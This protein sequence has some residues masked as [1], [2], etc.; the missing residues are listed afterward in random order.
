MKK[1]NLAVIGTGHLGKFH[2]EKLANLSEVNLKALVDI[3]LD[4]AQ[5]VA[6]NLKKRYQIEPEV[7]SDFRKVIE[8]VEAVVIATPTITHYEIAKEF[9]LRKKAVFLEKPIASSWEHSLE[10]VEISEKEGVPFQI[11]YVERF[12][13]PVKL[14]MEKVLNPLFIEAHRLS[15]FVERNLDIDVV[16][17]LMIH[18]LDLALYLKGYPKIKMIHAVGAPLFSDHYD[19]VNAR[20]VFEDETTANFTASRV[21]LKK[22]RRFRVFEK[23]VYYVV[24]TLEKS[25][26]E[27][28]VNPQKREFIPFKRGFLNTDPLKEE[29]KAFVRSVLYGER[30]QVSGREA[31]EALRLAFL[32]KNSVESHLQKLK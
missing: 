16:L 7:Y 2:A 32:I 29:L 25:F 15:S 23:G 6:K 11:G 20:V 4:K 1:I 27:I 21:S 26:L 9:L 18:D 10:L 31:L 22:E 19:I 12:Q 28:K 8:K 17:D 5:E 30:V 24:D 3:N 14:L 13:E